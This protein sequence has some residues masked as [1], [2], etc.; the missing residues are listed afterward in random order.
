MYRNLFNILV[1][2]FIIAL[3]RV[4]ARTRGNDYPE[5]DSREGPPSPLR[6]PSLPF[7]PL[8]A[9]LLSWHQLSL[10]L[11]VQFQSTFA[12]EQEFLDLICLDSFWVWSWS[13]AVW[14]LVNRPYGHPDRLFPYTLVIVVLPVVVPFVMVL[15]VLCFT[16]VCILEIM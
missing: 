7:V 6:S 4:N 13:R 16:W 12:K 11:C 9:P 14:R 10:T 15:E 5:T 8:N 3:S 1:R 2:M